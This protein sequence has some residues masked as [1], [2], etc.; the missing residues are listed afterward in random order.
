MH[1]P[2]LG[3]RSADPGGGKYLRL[4]RTIRKSSEA[5]APPEREDTEALELI[6]RASLKV[7]LRPGSV[8]VPDN[9]TP[10]F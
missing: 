3:R 10:L 5:S 7:A 4:A 1:G 9:I 6:L 8:G 2:H